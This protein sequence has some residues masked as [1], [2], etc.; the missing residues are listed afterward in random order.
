VLKVGLFPIL[1]DLME[2][3]LVTGLALN[4]ATRPFKEIR[5]TSPS[6]PPRRRDRPC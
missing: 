2:R 1:I 3:G 4:G 6:S 5:M